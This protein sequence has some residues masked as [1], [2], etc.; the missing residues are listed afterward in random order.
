MPNIYKKK[1]NNNKRNRSSGIIVTL[2]RDRL[3][4]VIRSSA[5]DN[6]I[7]VTWSLYR[8]H[9]DVHF[10]LCINVY[11]YHSK[12]TWMLLSN[13]SIQLFH[14]SSFGFLIE[15]Y[16]TFNFFLAR[17]YSLPVQSGERRLSSQWVANLLQA[18][19]VHWNFHKGQIFTFVSLFLRIRSPLRIRTMMSQALGYYIFITALLIK[20]YI[21][22]Y[23]SMC[24]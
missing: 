5:A 7:H 1:K 24:S 22:R 18:I 21:T 23:S 20:R 2:A 3:M 14:P 6:S 17:H 4:H 9:V 8:P 13:C 19:S 12:L 10:V 16:N 11:V 15:E